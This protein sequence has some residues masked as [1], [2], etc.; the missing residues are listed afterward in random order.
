MAHTLSV[1]CVSFNKSTSYLLLCFSP[2]SSWDKTSRTWGSMLKPPPRW[3]K[4]TVCSHK[5]A[6]PRAAAT[7][8]LMMLTP[9]YLTTHQSQPIGRMPTSWSPS[10]WTISIK[11]L[12]AP[13]R[14]EHTVMRALAH[15]GP[16]CLDKA[17]K[18]FFSTLPP[19]P[20]KYDPARTCKAKKISVKDSSPLK[21]TFYFF[22][23][24]NMYS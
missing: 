15:C 13:S 23:L 22:F 17:I 5:H 18:I 12:T 6:E 10:L 3:R 4:L 1:E 20:S 16:F 2:N 11:L 14:L 7:R 9:T 19:R 8:R 24:P 21:D